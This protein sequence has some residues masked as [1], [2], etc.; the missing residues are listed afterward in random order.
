MSS[1][2]NQN[3]T[4][5]VYNARVRLALIAL[6]LAGCSGGTSPEPIAK[7]HIAAPTTP[8][9]VALVTTPYEQAIADFPRPWL[10]FLPV[11]IPFG[12]TR[13]KVTLFNRSFYDGAPHPSFVT[14]LAI[15]EANDAAMRWQKAPTLLPHFV[16]TAR[17]SSTDWVKVTRNPANGRIGIAAYLP[18]MS[19]QECSVEITNLG[20]YNANSTDVVGLP[21]MLPVGD[22]YIPFG[23]YV[24]YELPTNVKRY[25]EIGD[26][27]VQGIA[28]AGPVGIEGALYQLGP[29]KGLAWS[30]FG[31]GG[32]SFATFAADPVG[33][34]QGLH[35]EGAIVILELGT[36]DIGTDHMLVDLDPVVSF[37]RAQHP[38][39][40][41]IATI[42]PAAIPPAMPPHGLV[43]PNRDQFNA[44]VRQNALGADYV[45]DR[46][47]VLRD[48]NDPQSMRLEYQSSDG[49]HWSAAA[50][51]ALID[52]L[53]ADGKIPR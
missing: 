14:D 3:R 13:V 44:L 46:D 16:V 31:V 41:W 4:A 12:V 53:V 28:S 8:F 2:H 17:G 5:P 47:A 43:D 38:A 23:V 36:N 20:Y 11:W 45:F 1:V 32:M 26:S 52:R 49:V 29:K 48:P 27:L 25:V 40:L 19:K 37:L 6:L 15:G 33:Q 22:N 50:Y 30:P 35:L 7:L 42:P 34:T 21:D 10:V 9:T 51:E 24:E 39:E 18:P